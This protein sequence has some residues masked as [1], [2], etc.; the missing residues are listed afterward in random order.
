[1]EAFFQATATGQR[2]YLYHPPAVGPIRGAVLYLHPWAEEMNKSRRMAA[3]QSRAL[4]VANYAVLQVDLHGCG[5]SSGEFADASWKDWID[6]A[7]MAAHWL[8]QRHRNTPLWLWGLRAGTLLA[9]QTAGQLSDACNLLLWQPTPS[10]KALL[11]QFLRVKA[12]AQMQHG[13]AKSALAELRRD[14]DEG[15]TVDVAGY[16]MSAALARGLEQATLQLPRSV[17]QVIWLEV[18]TRPG[19]SLLPA[20]TILVDSWRANGHGVAAHTVQG[21]TFWQTQEI[22]DA[23]ALIESTLMSVQ[24]VPAPAQ[25]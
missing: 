2:L 15:R 3:M 14:L 22:E 1:M 8:Q 11:Q 12:A 25:A 19:A 20:S 18:S 5:D 10:G 23:P 17:A 6:D 21:P 13:D 4:A 7:V 24:C 16:A 9:A